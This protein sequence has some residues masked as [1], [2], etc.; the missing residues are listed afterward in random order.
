[1]STSGRY[2]AG[3]CSSSSRNTPS[4]VILPSAWRSAEHDTPSPI[5]SDA[6]C[7]GSRITR[8]SW[9]KY[10][11]PNCAPTPSDCV[12]FSTSCSIARSRKAW[13]SSQPLRRQVVEIL[14]RGELHRLHRQL[15]RGAADH[16]RQVIRRAR[17]GAERQHL[18]L[19]ERHHAVVRQ[20]RRR[21]LEQERLVGRAAA[22]GDE[23]ELVAV[24]ALGIDLDLRRHVV[25]R[26]SSPRTSR[27]ARA[28]N[29]AGSCF[30]YASR[31]PSASAASSS[32]SVKTSR[33]FLPMMIAVPVSWH[34]GSTPPAA[35]LAFLRKSKAT[36]LS[37]SE[38]SGSSTMDLARRD[39]PGRSRWLMSMNAASE[40]AR[41]ASRETTSM[42]RPMMV[43]TRTP[44]AE[45]FR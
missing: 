22:L 6:P 9:Q 33:P 23:Q 26:C 15:G 35:M 39:A 3:L 34:I 30:R 44:S 36:N 4:L 17:R 31:A 18:L 43:S 2:F 41:I 19:E 7:R 10:L 28:A 45:I 13:P 20:D 8:T 11:P 27:A 32:P 1:M 37:L 12:I 14:G 21:R 24:L 40:S 38:A 5:G 16:D 42:S 29:S 25:A